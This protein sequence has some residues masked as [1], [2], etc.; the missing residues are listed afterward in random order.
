M[1]FKKHCVSRRSH[2]GPTQW[3]HF[4]KP[5][6]APVKF[7]HRHTKTGAYKHTNTVCIEKVMVRLLPLYGTLSLSLFLHHPSLCLPFTHPSFLS[8]LRNLQQSDTAPYLLNRGGFLPSLAPSA[9]LSASLLSL[10]HFKSWH[11]FLFLS[12]TH[13]L[14]LLISSI[15][16]TSLSIIHLL[17]SFQT[18][19]FPCCVWSCRT[20]MMCS[21]AVSDS[22]HEI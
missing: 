21:Y 13:C 7:K 2:E 1:P 11:S 15:L 18:D 3:E 12:P 5:R 10:F 20:S 22:L 8:L 19:R 16:L 6:W 9:S 17:F 14:S 4:L